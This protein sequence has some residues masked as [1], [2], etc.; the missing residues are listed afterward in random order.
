MK[1]NEIEELSIKL[2]NGQVI[3]MSGDIRQPKTPKR[4]KA[5]SPLCFLVMNENDV[6]TRDYI[7]DYS[8]RQEWFVGQIY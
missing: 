4:I 7:V 2:H 5:I 1:L 3:D 6:D 8:N